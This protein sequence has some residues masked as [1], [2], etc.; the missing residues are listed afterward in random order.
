MVTI[1]QLDNKAKK[2]LLQLQTFE[3]YLVLAEEEM[4]IMNEGLVNRN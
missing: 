4:A 1:G 2:H 3:L